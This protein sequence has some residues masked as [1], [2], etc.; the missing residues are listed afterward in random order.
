MRSFHRRKLLDVWRLWVAAV[1][2]DVSYNMLIV[3]LGA[4]IFEIE[5]V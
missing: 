4:L 5:R 2:A 3:I 1:P